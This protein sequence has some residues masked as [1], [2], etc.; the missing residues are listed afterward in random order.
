MKLEDTYKLFQLERAV[1][2]YRHV[3]PGGETIR[4]SYSPNGGLSD[5]EDM[6]PDL[7]AAL[8]EAERALAGIIEC[9]A[10]ADGGL[11]DAAWGC[12]ESAVAEREARAALARIRAITGGGDE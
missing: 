12:Q 3:L 5:L 1:R 7:A 8:I 9:P 2:C 10:I 6:A 11:G 4:T